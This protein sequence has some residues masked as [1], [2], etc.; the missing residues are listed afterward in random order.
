MPKRF[1]P[2]TVLLMVL[3]LVVFARMWC[4]SHPAKPPTGEA[5]GQ[6]PAIPA[7]PVENGR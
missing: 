4:A 2:H 3:A 5:G 7:T 6:R 1:P